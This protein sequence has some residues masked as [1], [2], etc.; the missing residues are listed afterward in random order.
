V[1]S[2]QRDDVA[3]SQEGECDWPHD[4]PEE[5]DNELG[6][7]ETTQLP[8]AEANQAIDS[9]AQVTETSKTT[10]GNAYSKE[11][12][13]S[14]M[15]KLEFMIT[16]LFAKLESTNKELKENLE[17]KIDTNS[18][19][20]KNLQDKLDTNSKESKRDF[21]ALEGKV[22]T[23]YRELKE[24]NDKFQ[25]EIETKFEKLQ[26]SMKADLKT[27]TENLIQRF[28]RENQKL[29]KQLTEKLDSEIRN[30]VHKVSEVQGEIEAELVAA[31]KSINTVQEEVERKLDQQATQLDNKID[32]NLKRIDNLDKEVVTI[33]EAIKE[34]SDVILRRQG[35][36]VEQ[37]QLQV[38]QEKVTVRNE[39]EK[40]NSQIME[41]KE[42]ALTR[43]NYDAVPRTPCSAGENIVSRDNMEVH[44]TSESTLGMMGNTSGVIN[45]SAISENLPAKFP[46][47]S[48]GLGNSEFP[49]PRFDDCAETNPKFH[50]KQLEEFF[51]LRGI[52][53]SC[54][55][56]VA[57]KSITG[58]LSKQWLEA[59][60]DKLKYYGDFKQ[61]FLNMWWSPSQQSLVK[62]SIYQ[63]KY[64][65]GSNL[66]LSGHF[67]KYATM[68]SYLEPR[69]SDTE[70]IEAI[71]CHFPIHIQRTMLGTQLRSIG[72]ALDLLKR[73]ELMEA[74]NPLQGPTN[75]T[76]IRH[77]NVGRSEH[78]RSSYDRNRPQGQVR[79]VQRYHRQGRNA[80][81]GEECSDNEGSRSRR[82]QDSPHNGRRADSPR[83]GHQGRHAEN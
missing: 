27:E 71:R 25:K 61:A 5:L 72:E 58:K 28:D 56:A 64:D 2:S 81:R 23:S 13:A 66:T 3:T 14:D 18:K 67:L 43:N 50:L 44:V 46:V 33:K 52:P 62:C 53:P 73:V 8:T 21:K 76:S 63:G 9:E 6:V 22:E 20:L 4:Q 29:N 24:C 34:N 60:S 26:E 68:A 37:M 54:Q 83:S 41:L 11:S 1:E 59:V 40:L 19:D 35:E 75:H 36:R 10:T 77:Q 78:P 80:F 15:S 30:V 12:N 32:S 7:D 51:Q 17:N 74:Q 47:A 70:A 42:L 69:P 31:K 16:S 38:H 48:S 39:I 55:L 82:L 65:R 57:K 45:V 49:L 79:Q